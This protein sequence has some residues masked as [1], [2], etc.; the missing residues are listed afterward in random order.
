MQT[1]RRVDRLTVAIFVM[2]FVLAVELTVLAVRFPAWYA[3]LAASSA[4]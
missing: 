4:D 1:T 3:H 2:L